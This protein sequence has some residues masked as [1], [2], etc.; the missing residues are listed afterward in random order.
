MRRPKPNWTQLREAL[1]ERSE[2]YCEIS[3]YPLDLETFDAHHRRLKGMGGTSRPD[4]DLLSNLLAL[5]PT[6]H[7]GGP[8]SMH[9]NP[10][11]AT[12]RGYLLPQTAIPH[13]EPV[14]LRGGTWV[15]LRDNGGYESVKLH[16]DST[17]PR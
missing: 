14:L 4:T 12:P 13:N 7:N 6:I 3:G 11:W 2:G 10:A 9:G 1:W 17:V 16:P 5:D 8:D 15:L